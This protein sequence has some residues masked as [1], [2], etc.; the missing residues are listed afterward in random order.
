MNIA[1]LIRREADSW[2]RMASHVNLDDTHYV[3]LR[4]IAVILRNIA[5]VTEAHGLPGLLGYMAARHFSTPV[6]DPTKKV[7]EDV[8]A[9][10]L[11]GEGH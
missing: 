7:I 2:A 11:R 5:G 9:R 1:D 4:M 3:S 8:I 10:I 6:T